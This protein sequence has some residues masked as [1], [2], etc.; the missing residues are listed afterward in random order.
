MSVLARVV[1]GKQL[2]S[3]N[4][5]DNKQVSTIKENQP[6]RFW[7]NKLAAITEK[8]NRQIRE[9]I[10]KAARIVINHCRENKIDTI[11]FARNQGQKNQ[12]ELGKKNN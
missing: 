7:S 3:M 6:T 5:N 8:R 9:G 4:R 12:I 1:D 11:V 10:N 2:K